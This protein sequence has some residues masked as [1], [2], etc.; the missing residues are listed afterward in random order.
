MEGKSHLIKINKLTNNH[1]Q[2]IPGTT[3]T[4]QYT[5]TLTRQWTNVADDK[6]TSCVFYLT[7]THT[8]TH[9]HTCARTNLP[10]NM[11]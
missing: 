11:G 2:P 5:H 6:Y 3:I 1:H 8:H 9:T 4:Y 7:H 10:S